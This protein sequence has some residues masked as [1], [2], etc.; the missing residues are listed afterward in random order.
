M[1]SPETLKELVRGNIVV[2]RV[3]KANNIVYLV[4]LKKPKADFYKGALKEYGVMEQRGKKMSLA[5]LKDELEEPF[6]HMLYEEFLGMIIGKARFKKP[7]D[8]G[9]F[10]GMVETMLFR[11]EKIRK[12]FGWEY[13]KALDEG[14][15]PKEL[16]ARLKDFY[17]LIAASRKDKGER[18]RGVGG[19]VLDYILNDLKK[20]RV[21]W[22]F[23]P[24]ASDPIIPILKH[25][26]WATIH[27][28]Y[29]YSKVLK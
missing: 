24:Q 25:K 9:I 12:E 28:K 2:S 26:G 17:P 21:K 23:V 22:V 29:S 27:E 7:K 8:A 15:K 10:L 13:E 18:G 20:M 16:V 11:L 4:F 1:A 14:I 3:Q 6:G 5:E 19:Y